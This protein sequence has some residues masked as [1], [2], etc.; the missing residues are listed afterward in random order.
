MESAE[1][2]VGYFE[3]NAV[4]IGEPVELYGYNFNYCIPIPCRRTDQGRR[5]SRIR[6]TTMRDRDIRL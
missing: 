4:F 5:Q 6:K 2:D 1:S 3:V